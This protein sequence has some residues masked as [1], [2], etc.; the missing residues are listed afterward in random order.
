LERLLASDL[1]CRWY[2]GLPLLGATP[3]H[4]TLNRFHAWLTVHQPRALF[5]DVL[6]FLD[7]VDPED[8]ATTPQIVDTFALQSAAAP[9]SVAGVLWRLGGQVTAL[10]LAHAPPALQGALPPL[11]LGPLHQV[12]HAWTRA[13]HQQQLVAA[14]TLAQWL[15]T[16]LAPRLG[17]LDPAPRG[18]V[19]GLLDLL[20][21]VSA[22]ETT[23]DAQGQV[24]ERPAK[25]KGAYRL[26]SA[27][28]WRPASTSM[29]TRSPSATTRPSPRPRRASA[30]W[31]SPPAARPTVPRPSPCWRSNRRPACRCP[32]R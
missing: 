30:P 27:I 21:K 15:R 17:A 22:D 6:A 26:A 32:R 20:T 29:T 24:I 5:A 4:S 19:Q 13:Q 10:W 16:D 14:V 2:V 31:W 18:A 7:R 3:D 11:D 9:T 12:P 23:T 1:V 25:D 28:M 8:P